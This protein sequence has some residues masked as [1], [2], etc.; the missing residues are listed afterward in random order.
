MI[1]GENPVRKVLITQSTD[2]FE[3]FFSLLFPTSSH[4]FFS[5]L[6]PFY[7]VYEMALLFIIYLYEMVQK[8]KRGEPFIRKLE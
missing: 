3:M 2:K 5:F 4:S 8:T 1:G 7:L 6:P